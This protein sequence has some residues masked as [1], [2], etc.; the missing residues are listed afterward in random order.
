MAKTKAGS[1]AAD[2]TEIGLGDLLVSM[3]GKPLFPAKCSGEN[4]VMNAWKK[5]KRKGR[6][7][8]LTVIKPRCPGTGGVFNPMRSIL[9]QYQDY[10]ESYYDKKQK[11]LEKEMQDAE[12]KG[13]QSMAP[14]TLARGRAPVA[15]GREGCGCYQ[16]RYVGEIV[17]GEHGGMG[18]VEGV[19]K[20]A[21]QRRSAFTI[22]NVVVEITEISVITRNCN[23]RR[24]KKN[25][26]QC[27]DGKKCEQC[28]KEETELREIQFLTK[29]NKNS[30]VTCNNTGIS[31][32]DDLSPSA[33][34]PG[35][36]DIIFRHKFADISSCGKIITDENHFCYIAGDT[37][38]TISKQFKGYVFEARSISQ[39][40]LIL[41]NI[42]QGFKR[43][44]W[45]M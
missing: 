34:S 1:A 11:R 12:E 39:A 32:D 31:S 30:G 18:Q 40:R 6:P 27:R 5:C 25:C 43:T 17:V 16:V 22:M 20:T 2:T 23:E 33:V 45:F 28:K 41:N 24:T 21:I 37:F 10:M 36:S 9:S 15:D 44:T 26:R 4:D 29:R 14:S 8:Q 19:I 42:Y 13:A 3:N 7:C 35:D 38:C